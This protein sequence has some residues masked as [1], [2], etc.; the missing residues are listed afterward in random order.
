M[1]GLYFPYDAD[2][3]ELGCDERYLQLLDLEYRPIGVDPFGE[4]YYAHL[5]LAGFV[6][7]CQLVYPWDECDW[8]DSFLQY[9][10]TKLQ[11]F[12]DYPH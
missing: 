5:I 3:R 8:G 11:F 2:S 12:A 10:G 9:N 6:T 1:N 4:V 7:P